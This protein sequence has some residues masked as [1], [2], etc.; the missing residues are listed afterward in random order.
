M[1]MRL[2]KNIGERKLLMDRTLTRLRGLM[3]CMPMQ[4]RVRSK[5]SRH[6]YPYHCS[7]SIFSKCNVRH[8]CEKRN[9]AQFGVLTVT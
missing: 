1:K 9:E 6:V 7:A 4:R 2:L 8:P 5:C 3:I